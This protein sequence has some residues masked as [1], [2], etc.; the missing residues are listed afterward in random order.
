MSRREGLS[1]SQRFQKKK[2]LSQL[3]TPESSLHQ[4]QFLTDQL[5]AYKGYV[6]ELRV[7]ILLFFLI[8]YFSFMISK[9][10]LK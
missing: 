5:T 4:H 8:Y 7:N 6:K 3:E 2:S 10:F 9:I 1:I